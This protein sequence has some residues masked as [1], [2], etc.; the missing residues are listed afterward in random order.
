ML[1]I[2]QATPM[3]GLDEGRKLLKEFRRWVS[4][5]GDLPEACEASE[6]QFLSDGLQRR[7]ARVIFHR[8][9]FELTRG[10]HDKMQIGEHRQHRRHRCEQWEESN[11]RA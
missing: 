7:D 1:E 6:R 10:D 4:G 8:Q 5:Q 2:D 9:S 11:Q 3:P